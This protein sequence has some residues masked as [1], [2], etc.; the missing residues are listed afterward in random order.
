MKTSYYVMLLAIVVLSS[1]NEQKTIPA[2][3]QF[4]PSVP[5]SPPTVRPLPQSATEIFNLRS[6][7]ARLGNMIVKENPVG[8]ALASSQIS[9]YE[10]RTNRCYVEVVVQTANAK[11]AP[12]YLHRYLFD[13]QTKQMLAFAQY[14]KGVKDGMIVDKSG[15]GFEDAVKHIEKVMKEEDHLQ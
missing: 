5:A 13:G 14:E 6:E 8:V 2:V 9:K 1:C 15:S 12:D 7:C 10:P 3:P 4:T 11:I